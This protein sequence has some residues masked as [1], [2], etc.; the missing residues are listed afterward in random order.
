MLWEMGPT[1]QV[2]SDRIIGLIAGGEKALLRSV[3]GAEDDAL[4]AKKDLV[5]L[6]LNDRDVL[7]GIT[8]SGR[9]PYVL[10]GLK[11]GKG[12]AP[13]AFTVLLSCGISPDCGFIDHYITAA[14]GPEVVTGS[15]RLKAG[16]VTKQILNLFS[17]T[18]M[19]QLGRVYENYMIDV[20]VSNEKLKSRAL[21]IVQNLT[22][23]GAIEAEALLEQANW[24]VKR[25]LVM[26]YESCD[27]DQACKVIEKHQGD[28]GN[29]LDKHRNSHKEDKEFAS[30][31]AFLEQ[32]ADFLVC[33][34]GGATKTQIHWTDREGNVLG[35]CRLA[36]MNIHEVGSLGV[37]NV[38]Q[39]LKKELSKQAISLEDTLVVAGVS[40]AGREK[41]DG[42]L[43]QGFQDCG[44]SRH[45]VYLRNDCDVVL[46]GV[47]ESG[48]IL[49]SG[50]GSHCV[51]IHQG[52][53][54]RAGGLGRI[55]GDE[56]SGFALGKNGIKAALAAEYGWG[57]KTSLQGVIAEALGKPITSLVHRVNSG[58]LGKSAV[59]ALA[60]HVLNE[61]TKDTVAKEIAVEAGKDLADL[62]H[63]VL[64]QLDVKKT[65][66][67]LVGG[68]W[69]HPSNDFLVHR[70]QSDERLLLRDLK[71]ELAGDS[72]PV[73]WVLDR[74]RR[75]KQG[76]F[77]TKN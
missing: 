11:E 2:S 71:W 74:L 73:L 51:G 47:G 70:M 40:G 65:M 59:A 66:V 37:Q 17:T 69:R 6:E 61:S 30:L 62:V 60:S 4:G 77:A 75:E 67:Y 58:D 57:R 32:Q 41:E 55:L 33:L 34:D 28:V 12:L 52:H 7:I 14:T 53:F 5:T 49:I 27:F 3:E 15:T 9:T 35:E 1:F 43:I 64:E 16:T 56:G 76:E 68:I 46:E 54:A 25:A 20:S 10:G 18:L 42:L 26:F 31:N 21:G 8:A 48:L 36:S 24:Q 50:T 23:L 45:Q 22:A 39:A 38:I 19:V 44:W 63:R 72:N 13:N 29:L